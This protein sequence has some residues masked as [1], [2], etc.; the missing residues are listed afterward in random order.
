M[1]RHVMSSLA[2]VERYRGH[3]ENTW[4]DETPLRDVRFILLDSETTGLNPLKDRI[5]TMGA[6]A[7][8]NG[9]IVLEDSFEALLQVAHNTSAVT[10]HGVTREES[11][12]GMEEPAALEAF[13][14]YVRDGVI[15]GH[16]IGHDVQ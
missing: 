1:A 4:T 7:V 12:A 8:V 5:I 9:E 14:E 11:E 15:V 16:H 3:F 13:L 10:V 6:V 2:F